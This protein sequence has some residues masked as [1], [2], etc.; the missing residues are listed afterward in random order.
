MRIAIVNDL[1]LAR[2]VLRRLVLSV[3]EH[4]VAWIAEDGAEAVRRAAQDRPDII[5]M[6]LV[7]PV[8]DGVEATRQIMASTPCPI[9]LV[10]S[11]VTGNLNQVYA[12]MGEGGL[13]AVNT[14]IFG[15]DGKVRN[16]EAIL[17]RIE[18]LARTQRMPAPRA[19]ASEAFAA[20]PNAS[21]VAPQNQRAPVVA[22]GASTGGP[23]AVAQILSALPKQFPAGVVVVQHIA[24]EFAPGLASWLASR[25]G[26]PVRLARQGDEPEPG[27]VL[28][29]GTD[30][31]LVLR[32]DLRLAYTPDPVAY[33][34]RPSIDALFSSLARCWPSRGVAVLLTGMGAD[35]AHGMLLLKQ[36]GWSTIAQDQSTSV[37]YGM[38]KAA[39][40][41]KAV[42]QCLPLSSIAAEIIVQLAKE[43]RARPR[44]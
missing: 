23:E 28:L 36:A 30:D 5:L 13:D 6:D 21:E 15:P 12:A 41:L 38:P 3:P 16:G 35:G 31:H 26:L 17:S 33:P 7:M 19:E 11:S 27:A 42:R 10:T 25:S 18:K 1:A 9:L 8:L 44:T 43:Q 29:A 4:T 2:E 37:V 34:Y 32:P 40:D 22:L 24:A 20:K 14:P 39:V